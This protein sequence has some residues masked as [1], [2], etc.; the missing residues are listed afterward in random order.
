MGYYGFCLIVTIIAYLLASVSVE[1]AEIRVD[2][3]GGQGVGAVF[4]GRI[5]PG[6]FDKLK[7]F[8]L[9]GPGAVEI[10]LASPGGDLAEAIR[11]GL[12]VRILNLSTVVP[13]KALTHEGR[14]LSAANHNLKDP[15]TNYTCASACFFVFVAGIYRRYDPPG[16]PVLGVHRP[17]LSGGDIKTLSR[18][19]I[20]AVN[21]RVRTVVDR[22]LNEMGVP[23]KYADSMFAVPP[24][25]V[26]WIRSD[27][28]ERDL[29]GYI[30]ALKGKV[31]TI[32][33]KRAD[34]EKKI[35]GEESARRQDGLD[36]QLAKKLK[37]QADC[38]RRIQNELAHHARDEA[39][40]TGSRTAP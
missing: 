14:E 17:V 11:V 15:K 30:P 24:R 1:S 19:Q 33:D 36:E 12:L 6:D 40:K 13:S 32:C 5:E 39:L 28:F 22:Y 18:D 23:L 35:L 9:N 25:G 7:N 21:D 16:P 29:A 2:P 38:R 31:D 26:R 20:A 10:Y 37:E 4:E 27:D 34:V 8:I 3:S